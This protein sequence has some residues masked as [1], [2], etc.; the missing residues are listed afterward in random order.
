ML[1]GPQTQSNQIIRSRT[2]AP[3]PQKKHTQ[4]N[5]CHTHIHISKP[6]PYRSLDRLGPWLRADS[7]LRLLPPRAF[8]SRDPTDRTGRG[9][10]PTHT[11]VKIKK[12]NNKKGTH[13]HILYIIYIYVLLT[14]FVPGS[15]GSSACSPARFVAGS[16]CTPSCCGCVCGFCF[17]GGGEGW[18]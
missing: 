8:V 5:K 2:P 7:S 17:F 4:I 18:M 13:T 3:P 15:G 10:P 6:I 1:S 14:G 9:H 12:N 11:Y 16:G